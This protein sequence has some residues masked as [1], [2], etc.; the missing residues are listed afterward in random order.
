MT[1]KEK[2]VVKQIADIFNETNSKLSELIKNN[3]GD[4]LAINFHITNLYLLASVQ[5]RLHTT[6][7]EYSSEL[8]Y[9]LKN[10]LDSEWE[11]YFQKMMSDMGVI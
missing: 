10:C 11:N 6:S 7:F 4:A 3:P 5:T 8:F 2:D 1:D 9:K